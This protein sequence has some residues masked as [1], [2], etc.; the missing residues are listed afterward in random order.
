HAYMDLKPYICT[1][2][3]CETPAILYASCHDWFQHEIDK[4][5]KSWYC[6][7]CKQAFDAAGDFRKH[8]TD[9]HSL[10]QPCMLFFIDKNRD[11][12]CPLCREKLSGFYPLRK[13]LGRHLQEL[14]TFALPQ[15]TKA[16]K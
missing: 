14:V 6:R 1:F 15:E 8:L 9:S 2:E 5:R 12:E 7:H 16:G 4:H 11:V 13:H 10:R 3:D